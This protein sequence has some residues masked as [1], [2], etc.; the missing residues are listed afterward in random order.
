MISGN[1]AFPARPGPQCWTQW[2]KYGDT[3]AVR[4]DD[5]A[6]I[7]QRCAVSRW[8]GCVCDPSHLAQSGIPSFVMQ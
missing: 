6:V 5:G 1:R 2:H 7:A 4:P 3:V 8:E